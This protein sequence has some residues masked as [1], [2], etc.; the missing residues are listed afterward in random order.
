MEREHT[1]CLLEG[2]EPSDKLENETCR[3]VQ[4]RVRMLDTVERLDAGAELQG[5]F[6]PFEHL[7]RFAKSAVQRGQQLFA[8]S[9]QKACTRQ[10]AQRT[11]SLCADVVKPIME[12]DGGRYKAAG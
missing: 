12:R 11:N 7:R 3:T 8:R 2:G 10:L 1:D 4:K 5:R 9:P 6:N